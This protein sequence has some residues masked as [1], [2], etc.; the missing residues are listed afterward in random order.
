[1]QHPEA[2]FLLGPLHVADAGGVLYAQTS[3]NTEWRIPGYS[4]YVELK[5]RTVYCGYESQDR[6]NRATSR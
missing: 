4:S 2:S 6:N 3:A 1:M 5:D